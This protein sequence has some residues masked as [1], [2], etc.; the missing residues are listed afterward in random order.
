MPKNVWKNKP[1]TLEYEA[2]AKKSVE[3]GVEAPGRYLRPSCR[4][5]RVLGVQETERNLANKISRAGSRP[6]FWSSALMRL[7]VRRPPWLGSSPS[8]S[9]KIGGIAN[10]VRVRSSRSSTF[11]T[12]TMIANPLKI[13]CAHAS[14]ARSDLKLLAQFQTQKGR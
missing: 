14:E 13:V 1:L 8:S 4:K 9:W 7:G 6:L 5:A 2:K 11:A 3:R 10:V 12:T